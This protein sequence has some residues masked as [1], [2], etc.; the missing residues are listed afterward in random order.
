MYICATG[1]SS[2][3]LGSTGE[4]KIRTRGLP[5]RDG[6]WA[7][8]WSVNRSLLGREVGTGHFK[9]EENSACKGQPVGKIV[10]PLGP[11]S[12]TGWLARDCGRGMRGRFAAREAP[13]G[14]QSMVKEPMRV[15]LTGQGRRNHRMVLRQQS[16]RS[17]VIHE[18]NSGNRTPWKSLSVGLEWSSGLNSL[19]SS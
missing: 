4:G 15:T 9:Q 3:C 16:D 5:G 19:W 11:L 10:V 1:D 2:M 7:G 6:T 17:F 14:R 18:D 12:S 8:C 13:T